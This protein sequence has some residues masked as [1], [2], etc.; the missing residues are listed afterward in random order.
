MP[1]PTL[2]VLARSS[3]IFT[4]VHW[5]QSQGPPF[6]SLVFQACKGQVQK[7]IIWNSRGHLEQVPTNIVLARSSVILTCQSHVLLLSG[8]GISYQ[9]VSWTLP[10]DISLVTSFSFFICSKLYLSSVPVVQC[11]THISKEIQLTLFFWL[12]KTYVHK[13]ISF[14]VYTCIHMYNICIQVLTTHDKVKLLNAKLVMVWASQK[15]FPRG[16]SDNLPTHLI[17]CHLH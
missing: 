8:Q 16:K 4:R 9:R 10:S 5:R 11:T 7:V 17:V 2:I 6:F 12:K 1:F 3:V 13:Y 15:G 14:L